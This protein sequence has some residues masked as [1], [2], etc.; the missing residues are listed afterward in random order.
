MPGTASFEFDP[1]QVNELARDLGKA[2][3]AAG[4]RAMKIVRHH[5][6][7]LHA[8]VK[9]NAQGRP[10]PRVQSGDYNRS[11]G[12]IVGIDGGSPIA[13]VGTN[14]PQGRRLEK[15]FVGTDSLG[16]TYHQPPYP[17]FEPAVDAI[18]LEFERDVLDEMVKVIGQ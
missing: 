15:G 2:S 11:I 7:R 3:A 18:G 9:A 10:G 16:R 8:K 12:L 14:R 6:M 17:H 13:R 5:G 4:A 1:A